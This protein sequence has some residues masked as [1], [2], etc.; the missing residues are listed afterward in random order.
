MPIY[1]VWSGCIRHLPHW[2]NTRITIRGATA[3]TADERRWTGAS[4]TPRI[5]YIFGLSTNT[6]VPG[7][8]GLH[9][10]PMTYC[11][12][13]R[14]TA[15]LDVVRWTTPKT[16]YGAKSWSHPRRVVARIEATTKGL[17]TRYV[18]YTNITYGGMPPR[19]SMTS[20]YCRHAGRQEEPD[21]SG[22]RAVTLA[23]DRTSCR[24]PLAN[25]R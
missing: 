25:Q 17:D 9:Q 2:P 21:Q 3:I 6:P 20:V 4:R 5:H 18:V 22:T 14:A 12:V 1:A 23:S 13:R 8:S 15:N 7:R 19:G 24:S 10:D 16:R 11:R